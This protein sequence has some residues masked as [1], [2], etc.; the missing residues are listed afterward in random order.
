MCQQS[1]VFPKSSRRTPPPPRWVRCFPELFPY[2]DGSHGDGPSGGRPTRLSFH[3]W[4]RMLMLR[5]DNRWRRDVRFIATLFSVLQKRMLNDAINFHLAKPGFEFMAQGGLGVDLAALR[6]L[7][8]LVRNPKT[9]M[10]QALRQEGHAGDQIETLLLQ[11][12]KATQRVQGTDAAR[13]R[14]RHECNA[15]MAFHGPPTWFFTFAPTDTN[16]P[17]FLKVHEDAAAGGGREGTVPVFDLSQASPAI[18]R[19]RERMRLVASDPVAQCTFFHHVTE[20]LLEG[21][22]GCLPRDRRVDGVISDEYG[23]VLGHL[24]TYKGHTAS[25]L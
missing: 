7:E 21:M 13:V 5:G 12:T 22:L 17:I 25:F 1:C 2:G 16:S 24:K 19:A 6:R 11:V 8:A 23:G 18:P 9:T 14:M 15:M 20:R 3:D 10:R 4:A